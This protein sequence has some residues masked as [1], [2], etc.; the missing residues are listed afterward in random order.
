IGPDD[1]VAPGDIVVTEQNAKQFSQP[2]VEGKPIR[3]DQRTPAVT[4]AP[5][6]PASNAESSGQTDPAKRSVRTVGPTFWPA[7]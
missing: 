2:R 1:T 5:P 7:R 4:S 3:P 6:A